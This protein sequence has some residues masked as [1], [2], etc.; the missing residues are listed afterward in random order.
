MRVGSVDKQPWEEF[1]IDVTF[2][3]P[4]AQYSPAD[5]I[6]SISVT[7]NDPALVVDRQS[8]SGAVVKAWVSA[9]LTGRT[10][11]VTFRVTTTG[12]RKFEAEA[13]VKVR[14]RA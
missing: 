3:A 5:T 12:G 2:A 1:D 7:S 11:T 9:G 8:Y 6:A 4:L 10:Y 13:K 14:E